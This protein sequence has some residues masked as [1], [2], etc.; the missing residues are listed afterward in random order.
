MDFLILALLI[1]LNGFFA[2]SEIALVTA[3]RSRLQKL[4]DAGDSAAAVAIKLGAEPT[5]FLSTVQIGITAIGILNGIAGEAAFAEPF[6]NWIISFD[7]DPE[8]SHGIATTLVVLSIT[9]LTI[10]LGELVPKRI[11]QSSAEPIALL[12][13]RPIALLALVSR[14]FVT[15]LAFSTETMLRLLNMHKQSDGDLTE[16]D[17]HAM[18]IEGSASGLIEKH[19]HAMVR[20]VLSLEDRSVSSL[21]TPRND[22]VWLDCSQALN[23]NLNTILNSSHSRFPVC[24]GDLQ[25]VLGVVSAKHLL[26]Q[27]LQGGECDLNSA[28]QPAVFVPES[29]TGMEILDQFRHSGVQMVLVVDEYGSVLGLLT[30]LDVLEA[31]AGEFKTEHEAPEESWAI[32]RADGSWLLDG[33]I[34]I[35]ELK[36]C[37]ALKTIPEEDKSHYHTLSGMFMLLLGAVPRTGACV[38]WEGWRLEVVDMDGNRVDKILAAQIV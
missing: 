36:D 23:A 30:L 31:L 19:E 9:Y 8:L 26:L 34:P 21:M 4:A 11:G 16:D 5:R 38:D 15:L 14:P 37:L 29:V 18:L 2:M 10:V 28:I 33:Q 25:N 32:Q 12:M 3:K 22:I 20:K 27:Q 13:A 7:I 24:D 17:I 6:A 1:L 35:Q